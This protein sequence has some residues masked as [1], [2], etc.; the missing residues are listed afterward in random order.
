MPCP[1]CFWLNVVDNMRHERRAGAYRAKQ[2]AKTALAPVGTVLERPAVG[3][4]ARGLQRERRC[5]ELLAARSRPFA[6]LSLGRRWPG[7][8]FRLQATALFR[9][10]LLEWSGPNTK[11]AVIWINRTARESRRM[12]R[13]STGISITHHSI[14]FLHVY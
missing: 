14:Q 5:L 10:G 12:S 8:N 13:N 3:N 11:R 4:C 9:L 7:R 2:F 1:T 6:R